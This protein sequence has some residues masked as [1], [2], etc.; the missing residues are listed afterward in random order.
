MLFTTFILNRK[1]TTLRAS[2]SRLAL[3]WLAISWVAAGQAQ[4][5]ALVGVDEVVKQEFTQ[6]IPL[7]GRLVAKQAGAT[8]TRIDGTVAA[9]H[10]QVGDRVKRNQVLATLDTAALKLR[11]DLAVAEH[12]G[13]VAKLQTA[14]AE[15]ALAK[16]DEERLIGLI[17][18]A[19]VSQAVYDDA[20]QRRRIAFTKEQE[21]EAAL[22]SSAAMLRLAELNLSYAKIKAPFA[23][24]VSTRFAEVGGYLQRGQ[25]VIRLVSDKQLEV[26][27]NI[28]Y[29]QVHGITIGDV[30]EMQLDNGSVHPATV[31]AVTA[32]EDSATRTRRVRLIPEFGD[33][34]GVLA[35]E[36]SV[37]VLIPLSAKRE[38]VSVHKDAVARRGRDNIVFVVV[39]DVA[40]M[41]KIQV[42]EASGERIEV[43]DGLQPGDITVVRGNERLQPNQ[44]VVISNP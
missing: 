31:R 34:A 5:A 36:Q 21:A 23:G 8:T 4:Q 42:G 33:D 19:A 38:I 39:D 13:A 3:L 14:H 1:L 15:F 44:K 22:Q 29:Y 25:P 28:P 20:I 16:Q 17:D 27:A 12:A 6:T 32:E 10:V 11:I 2:M 40:T 30:V 7:T 35:S 26:E 18:S 9:I 37:S 43:L 41:R 24:V